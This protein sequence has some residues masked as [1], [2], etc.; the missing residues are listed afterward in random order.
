[1]RFL[2]ATSPVAGELVFAPGETAA[3]FTVETFDNAKHDGDR[4][5]MLVLYSAEN[6]EL[7]FR[8]QTVLNILDDDPEDETLINRL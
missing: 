1:M 2:I 4:N 7:G 5:L 8:R 3:S 6:A